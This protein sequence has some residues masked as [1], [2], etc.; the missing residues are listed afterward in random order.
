MN[1]TLLL[2]LSLL[3]AE[4][5]PPGPD[6][7]TTTEVDAAAVAAAASRSAAK[8]EALL[9][10]GSG[11]AVVGAVG[12]LGGGVVALGAQSSLDQNSGNYQSRAELKRGGAAALIITGAG[13]VLVASGASLLVWGLLE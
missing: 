10:S 11:L 12:L 4:P 8:R 9:W 1:P 6:A 5:T 2:A 7:T 3:T 13:A